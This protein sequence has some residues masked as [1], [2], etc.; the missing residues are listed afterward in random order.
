MELKVAVFVFAFL[1]RGFCYP[2]EEN[3]DNKDLFQSDM[4]LTPMQRLLAESGGDVSLARFLES[5][6]FG[7]AK[8][9]GILWLPERIVPYTI[10]KELA[11][12]A[13]A[14]L[15]MMLA[16]REWESHTCL[17]FVE[18]TV[19]NDYIEFFNNCSGCWSYV[20]RQRG[21]QNICLSDGC[22]GKGTIVHE[23]AHAM[24]FW[25][26]Q[27]RPD[28]DQYINVVWSNIPAAKKHNF[29]KHDNS[30]VDSLGTKYDYTSVMQYSKTAFGINGSVTMD[31]KNPGVFQLGQRVGFTQTDSVQANMLYRCNG[32]T[33]RPKVIPPKYVLPGSENCDFDNGLCNGFFTQDK[34]DDFDFS[35]RIGS[36]PSWY[37]GPEV[38]HTT[39][40]MGAY[41]FIE[42]S[43]PRKRG[44]VARLISKPLLSRKSKC[45]TFFY[46][47]M[48]AKAYMMGT[49]NVYIQR[50]ISKKTLVFTKNSPQGSEWNKQSIQIPSSSTS[51]KVI[52]EAIR[53]AS[54]QGDI[55]IDDVSFVEGACSD[56]KMPPTA[57]PPPPVACSD[58]RDREAKYCAQWKKAGLCSFY[59]KD[60]QLFCPKSCGFC[61]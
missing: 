32:T 24:G 45:M 28:R 34:S 46:H 23:I 57:P 37:T 17:R 2:E 3:A 21:K 26:E 35:L 5:N 29:K 55:A 33:T 51:F 47:M 42:A 12:N 7:S 9:T 10:T 31:P 11:A 25:H 59:K 54:Y 40:R 36:T 6:A 15:G 16:F 8:D 53:G 49:F 44:H 39:S 1:A 60:L 38:D 48:A 50:G 18:R 61:S 4:R 43:S 56:D 14:T 52:F 13:E 19:E 27:S 20:G 30:E 58:V 41:A 22:W